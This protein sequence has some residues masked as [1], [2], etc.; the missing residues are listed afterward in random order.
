MARKALLGSIGDIDIRLLRIFRIVEK[1]GGLSAAELELN[2]GRSTISKH[3][4][5]LETRLGMKLCN[6]GPA[7]FS[8]TEEGRK[9][10]QASSH[11][12][13]AISSFQN[14]VNETHQ[15]LFGRISLALFDHGA[16]NPEA[17]LPEAI[18]QFDTVAPDVDLEIS[19]EPPN[20]I[21]TGVL[22][23]KYD[24][25]I[26]PVYRK[27]ASLKYFPI[28]HENMGLYCGSRHPLFL[29]A[30]KVTA[31]SIRAHKYAGFGFNSPNMAA[32]QRLKLRRAAEV[33]DEEAL[34]VLI[35]SG[36][37]VG[38]LPEHVARTFVEKNKM[39]S[40]GGDALKYNPVHAAIIRRQPTPSRKTRAFLDCLVS[41]HN[42]PAKQS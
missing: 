40:I 1:C 20:T 39:C 29:D 42:Q 31:S 4:S 38:F 41:V 30:Q 32:G 7:G 16:M 10:L 27:S 9:I 8:L 22:D 11:L 25:G 35:L 12:F 23:G 36:C 37:Y 33:Q 14:A 28:F 18:R 24:I 13:T 34:T 5:D 21:E 6:R 17:R 26:V 3:L 2:V 19:M 15:N